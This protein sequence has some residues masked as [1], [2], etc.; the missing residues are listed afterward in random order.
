MIEVPWRGGARARV[1][2]R[3]YQWIVENVPEAAAAESRATLYELGAKLGALLR[4]G[5]HA[6]ET[7]RT[8]RVARGKASTAVVVAWDALMAAMDAH[9]TY[10]GDQIAAC[11]RLGV[12]MA[13]AEKYAIALRAVIDGYRRGPS[14]RR[15]ESGAR[16]Q[17]PG[18]RRAWLAD[19]A[20]EIQRAL[21]VTPNRAAAI[22]AGMAQLLGVRASAGSIRLAMGSRRL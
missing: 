11:E 21:E 1:E 13:E 22:T 9:P 5:D 18:T 4:A 20:D 7:E 14:V 16:G 15:G 10:R 17:H 3:P 6:I 8:R 2:H 19:V 12:D